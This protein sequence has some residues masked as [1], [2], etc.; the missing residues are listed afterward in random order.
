MKINSIQHYKHINIL[1]NIIL[2]L[3][4]IYFSS[5]IINDIYIYDLNQ[6]YIEFV[7]YNKK[8]NKEY[9]EE[10][11]ETANEFLQQYE[12]NINIINLIEIVEQNKC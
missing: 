4:M 7:E 8:Y 11:Y 3:I 12:N 10:N 9:F 1:K 6:L 2:I 5:E